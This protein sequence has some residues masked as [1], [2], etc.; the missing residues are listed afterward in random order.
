MQCIHIFS[1]VSTVCNHAKK[2]SC[3]LIYRA[4]DL[5]NNRNCINLFVNV[6]GWCDHFFCLPF[7]SVYIILYSEIVYSF[8]WVSCPVLCIFSFSVFHLYIFILSYVLLWSISFLL[9]D[10]DVCTVCL[11]ILIFTYQLVLADSTFGIHCCHLFPVKGLGWP[12]VQLHC[13]KMSLSSILT[14]A[15]L[16]VPAL[17][18]LGS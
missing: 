3:Q 10:S 6:T 1:W 15:Y 4:F 8:M 16:S 14:F 17:W 11:Y 2:W 9:A 13:F 12:V 7:S 5:V 18:G